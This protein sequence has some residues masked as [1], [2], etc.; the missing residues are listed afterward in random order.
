MFITRFIYRILAVFEAHA[1]H[2][3]ISL[4]VCAGMLMGFSSPST[5]HFWFFLSLLFLIRLNLASALISYGAFSLINYLANSVFF[6]FGNSLLTRAGLLRMWSS[7]YEMPVIPFTNFYVPEVLGKFCITL[8][9]VGPLYFVSMKLA[10]ILDP[11]LYHW[12]RT[13]KLYTLYRSYKPYAR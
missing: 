7:L 13:T 3:N 8:I 11:I 9:T 5:L 12:W 1:T 10:K 6:S 2:Q 4:G